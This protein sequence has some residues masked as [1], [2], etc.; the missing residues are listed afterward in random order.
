MREF[1]LRGATDTLFLLGKEANRYFDEAQPWATRK[2]DIDRCATSLHVCC[3]F[4][5]A[6]CGLY[7]PIV[8]RAMQ[9]LWEALGEEGTLVETGWPTAD[10]WL[11]EGRA[12][13]KP[14]ILFTKIEDDRIAPEKQRLEELR[15]RLSE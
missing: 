6:F 3:Q 5:R 11:P 13:S 7:A 8:P 10:R 12:I 14:P 2:T 4:V 1:K 9:T 15:A